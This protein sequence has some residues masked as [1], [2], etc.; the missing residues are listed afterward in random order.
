MSDP[1]KIPQVVAMIDELVKI[2]VHGA[3]RGAVIEQLVLDQLK[4]L[5]GTP[6]FGPG[7]L[8]AADQAARRE[9]AAQRSRKDG[10]PANVLRGH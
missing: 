4:Y 10:P 6:G 9:E 5:C 7:L 1:L 8:N 2:G 3:G